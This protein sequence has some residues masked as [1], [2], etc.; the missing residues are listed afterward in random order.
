MRVY[1]SVYESICN[2]FSYIYNIVYD[3]LNN[4]YYCVYDACNKMYFKVHCK[5]KCD[6]ES[7]ND[8]MSNCEE[9]SIK[10]TI[11]YDSDSSDSV[12]LRDTKTSKWGLL[13]I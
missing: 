5:E 11:Y 12:Y 8:T 10:I 6:L 7:N 3:S 9:E 4:M 2:F 13:D 1:E